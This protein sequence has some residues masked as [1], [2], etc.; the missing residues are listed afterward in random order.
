MSIFKSYF[1]KNNTIISNSPT[2]TAK[3]PV[4][5]IFYGGFYSRMLLQIDLSEMIKRMD[6][7]FINRDAIQK[8][9][10]KLT[11]TI[12]PTDSSFFNE[13]L[14][15]TTKRAS[16]FSLVV[17][18]INESWDEGTGYDYSDTRTQYPN[19]NTYS[20]NASNWYYSNSLSLWNNEG[21]RDNA[22]IIGTQH[23]DNGN[24]NLEIDITEYI[25]NVLD[26]N[27]EHYGL[28][29]SFDIPY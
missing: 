2:N 10:L 26:G 22:D 9:V 5:E 21:V 24:E 27:E 8:H 13:S 3:N 29:I 20:D 11:N 12:N 6:D 19:Q 18:K 4:S 15:F 1:S 23:F 28:G 17:F 25:N 16:S 7:G 14:D